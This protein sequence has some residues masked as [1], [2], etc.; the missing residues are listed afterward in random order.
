DT[1]ANCTFPDLE[2]TWEFQV[3]PSKGGARNRDID[4]SKLGP[5]EKKATVTIKQLNIAEDNLG[6]VGFVTL[7]Y[8]QG[9][10]VVIGSYKWFAFFR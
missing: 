3:S 1:P 4:C 5:V 9:F 7:I 2:G 6:N 10:E 8:N